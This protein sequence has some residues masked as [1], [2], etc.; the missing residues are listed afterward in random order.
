MDKTNKTNFSKVL[1]SIYSIIEN[2]GVEIL[3]SNI[4][5]SMVLGTLPYKE[6][7]LENNVFEMSLKDINEDK[8]DNINQ[9]TE[10]A[11]LLTQ[12]PVYKLENL[13]IL[14]ILSG[15]FPDMLLTI[16]LLLQRYQNSRI[17]I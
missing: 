15:N 8:I 9:I 10:L 7:K 3:A 6:G 1:P 2:F 5:W 17:C 4:V 16:K 12:R 14:H 13:L 11:K